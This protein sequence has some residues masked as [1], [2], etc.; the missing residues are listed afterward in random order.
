MIDTATAP[1]PAAALT[2]AA[3]AVTTP[4]EPADAR[5]APRTD[6][7]PA[8]SPRGVP[9]GRPGP[10]QKFA[11]AVT[12]GEDVFRLADHGLFPLLD[13]FVRL[14]LAQI[15]WVSGIVKLANWQSAL[16]LAA[17][18]YPVSWLDPVTA[19]R[20]GVTIELVGPVLLALGL[21]T[22]FAALPMLVLSLVIQ[23]A[24]LPL[25]QHQ[26]WA[27]LFGW[28]VV[29]GAG[30]I[31][32][33]RPLARGLAGS[34]LPFAGGLAR[35]LR[36]VTAYGGPVTLLFLRFWVAQIFF[37]SG[38]TKIHDW[39]STEFLF[40]YEY[41][42]PLLPPDL[43]AVLATTVEL[44]MPVLLVLG[45]ATRLAALPLI[46]MTLVIQFTYLPHIDHLYWLILLALIVLRGPG[47]LSLDHA[48]CTWLARLLPRPASATSTDLP[49]V[50]VVGAGFGGA[51][52]A[53]ALRRAPCR[54]TVIDRH[55]YHLFQPLLYQVAT[56]GLSP[57]DIAQ[58]VR[59]LFRDQANARV[60]LGRVTGVDTAR[61]EVELATGRIGYDYLI[62]A[63]GAR[64]SYFDH[65]DWAPFAPGLKKIE[66]ATAIR[67]RILLAFEQ[68]ET[69]A[70]PA[71]QAKLLTFII[72]GGGPTGVE[73]AGAIAELARHGLE[74]E[75]RTI[76][77]ARARVLLVQSGPRILPTFPEALSAKAQRALEGIGVEVMTD[78]RV[79]QVDGD[80]AVV[81]G[82]RVP[83]RT[84]FW[85]AGV[86]ASSAGKWVRG[87]TD[88]SGRVKVGPDLSV[89]GLPEV[90]AIGDTALSEGWDGQPVP[91][92]APAAKQGGAYVARVIRARLEGRGAP[93]PFRYHHAGSLAT[94]GRKA[95]VADFGRFKL[96]G[97]LAWW[98]WGAVHIAF[99]VGTRNRMAVA[100]E[101]FWAYLTFRPSTRL[102]TGGQG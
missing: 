78:R 3:S 74:R 72:V 88:R 68:A 86:I 8:H 73:L 4:V 2:A 71:E 18:E 39:A 40:A 69:T 49:H 87:A 59:S 11:R 12:T 46:A 53:R 100:L 66:D 90:F 67:A 33:D 96:S 13:L 26:F 92:L 91:G 80:G 70:D 81:S 102:I 60:L 19:A 27:I 50:V 75:F 42:V 77:P 101:W 1:A 47:P 58:P 22:R 30:P 95:A 20:L 61:R 5:S 63:T 44:S 25:P 79:E 89:P 55:N 41:Q 97:A 57:A 56:A 45:L 64:H 99:L 51:A 84:V 35:L 24:Y 21:A 37:L 34:A 7:P 15:F 76:D 10:L 23:Y 94:V 29:M 14:W 62:L 52:A 65:D 31:A 98:L 54:V 32:L 28:Y 93:R 6:S 82:Q 48:A 38:L 9:P 85:A 17:H 83:S 43:A 16:Y 36:G